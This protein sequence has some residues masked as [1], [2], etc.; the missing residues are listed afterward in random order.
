MS[1]HIHRRIERLKKLLLGLGAQVEDALVRAI[2]AVEERDSDLARAVIT[3]D[4]EIDRE[5]VEL[6]EECLSLLALNQ[7][8]ALDLRYVISTLKINNELERVAD[9]AASVAEQAVFLSGLPEVSYT[10]Y[11][12]P[13][14]TR[15]VRV[16]VRMSL[17]ALVEV[18][19][20]QA[21]KV[22][23]ADQQVDAI[24]ASMYGRVEEAVREDRSA[25][26]VLLHL[27]SVSRNLER[28]ADHAVNIAE[29]VIYMAEGQIP[30][31]GPRMV[32]AK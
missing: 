25:T 31:H 21:R 12:L 9:L 6:E 28:I 30:R 27:L 2:Q 32:P 18:D 26:R 13:E 15:R 24:H 5:E 1:I 4:R 22:V 19:A 7:P 10:A 23:K 3:G 20:E 16:M 17:D 14:M 8:V 29:D 11:E